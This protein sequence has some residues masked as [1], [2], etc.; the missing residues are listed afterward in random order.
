MSTSGNSPS[1]GMRMEPHGL[2]EHEVGVGWG[3]VGVV[4]GSRSLQSV[5]PWCF[6]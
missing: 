6:L 4:L 5:V 3:G 2:P 1:K